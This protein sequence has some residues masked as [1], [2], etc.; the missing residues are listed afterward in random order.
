MEPTVVASFE[1]LV[2]A[3]MSG[4]N[5]QRGLAEDAY[6]AS[7]EQ[8]DTLFACLVTLLRTSTDAQVRACGSARGLAGGLA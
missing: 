4:D 7:K 5:Q 2:R 6:N 1:Q 8:P 3:L